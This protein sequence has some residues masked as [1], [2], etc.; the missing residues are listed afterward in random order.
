VPIVPAKELDRP[1]FWIVAGPNGSG[2]STIY[3]G[4]TIK[5]FNRSVWIINPDLLTARIQAVESTSPR[6]ANLAAVQRIY[7]WLEASIAA[8]QTV[9][10]ETVLST[11]KYRSLVLAA[12]NRRFEIR[13]IYVILKSADLNVERVRIRVAEGG[14]HVAKRKIIE[15]RERSLQ[16]LPWFLEHPDGAWLFDNSGSKPRLIGTKINGRIALDSAALPEIRMAVEQIGAR[17]KMPSHRS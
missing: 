16:Q 17:S 15:R 11:G 3:T 7:T 13:L 5:D 12:K 6:K 14:H 8:H 4:A 9:G 2:K 10:V 1:K